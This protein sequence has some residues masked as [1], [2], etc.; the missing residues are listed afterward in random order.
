MAAGLRRQH[1]FTRLPKGWIETA[2]TDGA[3]EK[4]GDDEV[5]GL[6]TQ[7]MEAVKGGRLQVSVPASAQHE[8]N[9]EAVVW[10]E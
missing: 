2:L 5:E 7:Q 8:A 9:D 4:L 1:R 3:D 6:T 10:N